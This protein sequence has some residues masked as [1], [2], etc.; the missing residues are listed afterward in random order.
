[1]CQESPSN[2]QRS[3]G[4][5]ALNIP[6]HPKWKFTVSIHLWV[7][8]SRSEQN[9]LYRTVYPPR[10][11]LHIREW[12]GCHRLRRWYIFAILKSAYRLTF[13]T[14]TLHEN[15]FPTTI[16]HRRYIADFWVSAKFVRISS[17]NSLHR[18]GNIRILCMW[19]LLQN[20]LTTT[21]PPPSPFTA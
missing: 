16:F 2:L 10:C 19:R 11:T 3:F 15:S 5:R 20:F 4:A 14:C 18:T 8:Y 1:M 9:I 7:A 13:C 17:E 21:P 6:I 12:K